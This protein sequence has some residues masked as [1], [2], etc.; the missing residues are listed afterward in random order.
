MNI[1]LAILQLNDDS[2]KHLVSILNCPYLPHAINCTNSTVGTDLYT[3]LNLNCPHLNHILTRMTVKS[4]SFHL[5][6]NDHCT[7]SFLYFSCSYISLHQSSLLGTF[8]FFFFWQAAEHCYSDF[9]FSEFPALHFKKANLYH[10]SLW[11]YKGEGICPQQKRLKS[12][13]TKWKI[14]L[15]DGCSTILL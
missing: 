3:L 9:Q 14:N 5:F 13:F 8:S 10:L 12:Y 7:A 2:L 4:E 1:L 11:N 6:P 15:I